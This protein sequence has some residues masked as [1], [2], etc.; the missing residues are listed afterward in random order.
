MHDGKFCY[1]HDIVC[2]LCT[3]G[4][5]VHTLPDGEKITGLTSLADE[6]YV[7]RRK[8]SD[9]V[10]VYDVNTY[11]LQR[12]LTVPVCSIFADMASCEH[13]R[14]LYI[15]DPRNYCIHRLDVGLGLPA[16]GAATQWPVNDEPCSISVNAAHN[17]LVLCEAVGEYKIKEF[18]SH[19]DIVREL[20]LPDNIVNP[21]QAIQLTN[22]QFVVCHADAQDDDVHVSKVSPDFSRIPHSYRIQQISN[23][24]RCQGLSHLAVD[25]NESVFV[26]EFND[27]HV[28]LLSPTLRYIRQV[29]SCDQLRGP[30]K[31]YLDTHRRRLYVADI[32]ITKGRVVVI[33]V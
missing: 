19:G 12:R 17:V 14:C 5:V 8:D 4:Q 24:G 6:I 10:E 23:R 18:S 32:K 28:K 7:L 9:Q 26:S 30:D 13:Y 29:V 22:G 33:S 31:L 27:R 15:G 1:E 2:F 16:Q 20:T 25:N 3:V 11:R 21:W